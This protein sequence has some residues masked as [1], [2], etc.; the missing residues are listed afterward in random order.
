[1]DVKAI[2][3]AG[4]IGKRMTNSEVPKQFIEICGKPII[5]HTIKHF[6]ESKHVSNIIVSC[7]PEYINYFEKMLLRYGIKDFVAVVEGGKTGQLSIFNALKYIFK[8]CLVDENSLVMIHDSVRPFINKKLIDE[9]S[10]VAFD[11]GS[12]VTAYKVTETVFKS[13]SKLY[14]DEIL[15]RDE[16]F[17]ARAPQTFNFNK[18]YKTHIKELEVGK[19]NNIDSASMMKKYGVDLKIIVSDLPNIKITTQTDL[20]IANYFCKVYLFE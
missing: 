4:G 1:M 7:N 10:K 17:M 13:K 8:D 15:D 3:L 2:I 16:M 12:A 18:L 9:N 14:V 6:I 20:N 11:Y 5:I 19:D